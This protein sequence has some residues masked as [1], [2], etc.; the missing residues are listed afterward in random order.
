MTDQTAAQTL[1]GDIR[2]SSLIGSAHFASHYYQLTLASLFPFMVPA[3]GASYVSL[4]LVVTVMYITSGVMQALAGVLVDRVGGAGVL[5]G[6]TLLMALSIGLAGLT[7]D[8]WML[9]PLAVAA[10]IG[11]SIYHPADLSILSHRVTERRLG[12][13]YAVHSLAGVLGYA[14]API[15]MIYLGQAIGW[16]GALGVAALVGVI[17]AAILWLNIDAI[18]TDERHRSRPHPVS[19]GAA[20][21]DYFQLVLSPPV[22]MSFLFFTTLALVQIGTQTMSAAANMIHFDIDLATAG[23]SVTA[24]LLGSATGIITGGVLADR[25][26]RHEILVTLGCLWSAGFV[27]VIALHLPEG[28]MVIPVMTLAGFGLGLSLPSRDLLVRKAAPKGATGK[29]FGFVY[30]G[31]DCGSSLAPLVFAW[32]IDQGRAQLFWFTIMAVILAIIPSV[33]RVGQGI[34]ARPDTA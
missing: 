31:L 30:S 27:L 19:R 25:F 29:I 23:W 2:T 28:A 17:V 3:L 7:P 6:G 34:Q 5:I 26:E 16:R 9:F 1:A 18:R 32:M 10:G 24:L 4:G 21:R 11:N 12:R 15:S 33:L 20:T 13:A 22:L 14:A 8:I